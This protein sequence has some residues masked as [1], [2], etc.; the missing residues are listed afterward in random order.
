MDN[1]KK[2]EAELWLNNAWWTEKNR[3]PIK[4]K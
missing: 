1:H 3:I 4:T 2:K